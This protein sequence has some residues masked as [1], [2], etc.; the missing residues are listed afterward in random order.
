MQQMHVSSLSYGGRLHIHEK[1][2]KQRLG[3]AKTTNPQ[4]LDV[5]LMGMVLLDLRNSKVGFGLGAG[6]SNTWPKLDPYIYNTIP[7]LHLYH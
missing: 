1:N 4:V 5:T 7:S 6:F 2:I 3:K